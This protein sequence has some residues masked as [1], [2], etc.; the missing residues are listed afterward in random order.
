MKKI[1]FLGIVIFIFSIGIGFYFG[2]ALIFN[3]TKEYFESYSNSSNISDK[4]IAN[5]AIEEAVSTELKVKP[6]MEFGIKEYFDECG[7]FNFEYFELPKELVNMSRQEIE[8]HY[9]GNYEVEEFDDKKLI[10][11]REINGMC[12]NHYVIKLNDNNLI[13]VYKIN[14]DTSYTLFESTEISKEFLPSEDVQK[15]EEGIVV[16]GIGKV[17]SILEDYE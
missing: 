16:Y 15:L 3:Q 14:T 12:D 13:D 4:K 9:N 6:N 5:E 10:L 17:N 1:A 7:H 2:K 8:D 11:A